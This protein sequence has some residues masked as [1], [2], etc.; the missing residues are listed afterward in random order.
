MY[1]RVSKSGDRSYLQIVEGYRDEAGRVKQKVI[2]NL[3]RL[4]K[5]GEK[6]LS[7]LIHGLQRA[8]G[9]PDVNGKAKVGQRA[10][11]NVATLGLG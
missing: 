3:G 10:A 8:I 9:R 1:V 2:A 5:M 4:D 6:D 11:Q 7:A